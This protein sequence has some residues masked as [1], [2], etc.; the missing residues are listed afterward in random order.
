MIF[1]PYSPFSPRSRDRKAALTQFSPAYSSCTRSFQTPIIL[2]YIPLPHLN[3]VWKI[4]L[5]VRSAVLKPHAGELVVGWV[6]TSESSLFIGPVVDPYTNN[7]LEIKL[8][9][10]FDMIRS[11]FIKAWGSSS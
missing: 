5:P 2:L 3:W 7:I 1:C 4:G 11:E 6:T 8:N 9:E 10:T